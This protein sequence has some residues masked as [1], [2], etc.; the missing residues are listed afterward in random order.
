MGIGLKM[1]APK[2]PAQYR[3]KAVM[4]GKGAMVVGGAISLFVLIFLYRPYSAFIIRLA[5][6]ITHNKRAFAAFMATILLT[7]LSIV[8]VYS[9]SALVASVG[10][11]LALMVVGRGKARAVPLASA[12]VLSAYVL[13]GLLDSLGNGAFPSWEICCPKT[14]CGRSGESGRISVPF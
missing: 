8:M 6:S 7:S 4:L 13:V 5:N 14:N 12:V 1:L 11:G 2:L 9:A 3:S 10:T